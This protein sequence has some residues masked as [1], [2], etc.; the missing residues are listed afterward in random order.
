[1]GGKIIDSNK[2]RCCLYIQEV[3]CDNNNYLSDTVQTYLSLE[4]ELSCKLHREDFP[5]GEDMT[6]SAVLPSLLN[7]EGNNIKPW[8]PS[9]ILF[10]GRILDLL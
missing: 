1:M 9:T 7:G 3:S 4:S 8:L 10:S 5:E 6:K 2:I